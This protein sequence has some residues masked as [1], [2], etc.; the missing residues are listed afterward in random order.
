MDTLFLVWQWVGFCSIVLLVLVIFCLMRFIA[1]DLVER[2]SA[3]EISEAFPNEAGVLLSDLTIPARGNETT[4]ID[5][6]LIA[7]HGLYVI[8]QKK[9]AGR[10]VG[11]VENSHWCKYTKSGSL[12]L[13]NPFRQNYGHIKAIQSLVEADG[14][15]C[16]NVVLING[17]CKFDGQKPE[18]LCMG[19]NEFVRKVKER[20]SY[21]VFNAEGVRYI[22][23]QLQRKREPPGLYTDLQHIRRVTKKHNATMKFDQRITLGLIH[24]LRAVVMRIKRFLKA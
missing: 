12:K 13:Q 14:L 7:S 19:T 23:D 1:N 5:H 18:W 10:L 3:R 22:H 15:Q 21:T 6:V 17:P 20:R 11:H 4:Q 2:R 24:V 8:E 16:I 9:Y